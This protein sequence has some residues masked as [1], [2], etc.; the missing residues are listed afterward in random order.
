MEK[1][2]IQKKLRVLKDPKDKLN[3]LTKITKKESLLKP[4]TRNAVY[5]SLG[6]MYAKK[7][8]IQHSDDIY[9]K[10]ALDKAKLYYDKSGNK[11][12][13]LDLIEKSVKHGWYVGQYEPE[14]FLGYIELLSKEGRK[15]VA[16]AE[17][18]KNTD[19][20]NIYADKMMG[21]K[22]FKTKKLYANLIRS[23]RKAGFRD[24]AKKI[25]EDYHN[26]E[27]KHRTKLGKKSLLSKIV[28]SILIT[29]SMIILLFSSNNPNN[30]TGNVVSSQ[31]N[32]LGIPFFLSIALIIIGGI[33]LYK[34]LNKK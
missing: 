6:D 1:R 25:A 4:E 16:K 17:Y 28:G 34:S 21:K 8:I 2:D 3:Y 15:E 19:G 11:E 33:L 30:P 7:A 9:T 24:V 18:E 29:L 31:T 26:I 13:S 10:D 23:A 27:N 14:R 5:E 32:F 22:D 20:L 12:K